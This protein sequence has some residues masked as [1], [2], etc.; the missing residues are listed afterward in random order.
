MIDCR[1]LKEGEAISMKQIL[2]YGEKAEEADFLLFYSGWDQ[3]WGTSRYF[4]EYP[5]VDD[6]VLDIIIQGRYKGIGFDVMGLDP[7]RDENLPRH[8]KLFQGRNM[9][10]IENLKNLGLCG[11]DLF[12]FFCFPMKIR[13]S[14]GAPVRAAACVEE[15]K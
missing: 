15:E 10:N 5:C 1:D 11:H 4:G 3:Y 9:V 12:R 13:N 2:R 7:I 6:E 14:D 8:K